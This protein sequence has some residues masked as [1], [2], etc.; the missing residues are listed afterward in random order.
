LPEADIRKN[1][2]GQIA[3]NAGFPENVA[4]KEKRGSLT[5]DSGFPRDKK[6]DS[7]N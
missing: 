6:T 3:Y 4:R 7:K 5:Q 2:P 1:S